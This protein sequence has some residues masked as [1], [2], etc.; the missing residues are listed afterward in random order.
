MKEYEG[1]W[2]ELKADDTPEE[3]DRKVQ[4]TQKEE[5]QPKEEEWPEPAVSPELEG[6]VE[7]PAGMASAEAP[8]GEEAKRT[9]VEVLRLMNIEA[10]VELEESEER[11]D[12]RIQS[13]GS[14][15]LIGRRGQTLDALQYLITKMVHKDHMNWKRIVIDTEGYRARRIESLSGLARRLGDKAKRTGRPVSIDPM[16][17]H[18]RRIVHITLKDDPELTTESVGEGTFKKMI[19]HPAGTE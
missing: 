1:H 19:I 14:G 2:D 17:P 18:D 5:P 16:N 4:L 13:D 6:T 7:K 9:L 11:V 15:L 3:P 12:L 10:T 8:I